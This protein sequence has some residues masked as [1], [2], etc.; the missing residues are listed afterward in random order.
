MKT[1]MSTALS[2]IEP[3]EIEIAG[4]DAA[5]ADMEIDGE[6]VV[7]LDETPANEGD[8]EAVV[9]EIVSDEAK[10]K[11]YAEQEST[12]TLDPAAAEAAAAKVADGTAKPKKAKGEKKEKATT[13]VSRTKGSVTDLPTDAFVLVSADADGDLDANKAAVLALRPS[14]KKIAEKFDNLFLAM[15]AGKL[16]SVYTVEVF[17]ALRAS[18]LGSTEIVKALETAGYSLGTSRSQAQQVI[19]LFQT[20]KIATKNEGKLV[21]N[22]DSVLGMALGMLIDTPAVA[23]A[24]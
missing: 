6:D 2:V 12:T 8:I 16:P 11:A 19:Q 14:A 18:A 17:K 13:G 3:T 15:S 20:L 7:I 9:G 22:P 1:K 10:A 21:L 4:L 23:P 5:L 24:A